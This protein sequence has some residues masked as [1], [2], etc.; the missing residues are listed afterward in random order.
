MMSL[1]KVVHDRLS[2]ETTDNDE[3]TLQ[4]QGLFFMCGNYELRYSYN[5]CFIIFQAGYKN[6]ITNTVTVLFTRN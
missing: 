4:L 3:P 2:V 5:Y 1:H 6:Y